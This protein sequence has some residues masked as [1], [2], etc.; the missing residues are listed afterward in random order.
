MAVLLFIS[1]KQQND[2]LQPMATDKALPREKG[3]DARIPLSLYRHFERKREIFFV[4]GHER[5]GRA[6]EN[7]KHGTPYAPRSRRFIREGKSER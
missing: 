3:S 6:S 1:D 2:L 7:G 5:N 4:C